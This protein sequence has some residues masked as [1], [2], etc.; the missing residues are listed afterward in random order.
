MKTKNPKVTIVIPAFN[1]ERYLSKTLRSIEKIKTQIPFEVI[2]VNNASTDQNRTRRIFEAF[3][4]IVIDEPVKGLSKAR[5]A[6]IRAARGEIIIQLDADSVVPQTFIDEHVRL[7]TNTVFVGV[8][9][10]S[11][12]VGVHP[13]V[14]GW[15]IGSKYFRKL[16]GERREVLYGMSSNISYRRNVA[17]KILDQYESHTSTGEDRKMLSL[18]HTQG[19][20]IESKGPRIDTH[21]NGRKYATTKQAL[22]F[23]GS[24]ICRKI[25]WRYKKWFPGHSI[26]QDVR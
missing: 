3:R 23:I 13:L 6:G 12:I 11:H 8:S 25:I 21:A 1:E 18:L 15:C 10:K 24:S 20:V 9:A 5:A 16:L 26:L 4:V 22:R 2:G 17:L 14:R 19:V 7:Y